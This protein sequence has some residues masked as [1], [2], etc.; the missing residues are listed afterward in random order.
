[1]DVESVPPYLLQLDS[2]NVHGFTANGN[3][4]VLLS[5]ASL[6]RD[7]WRGFRFDYV[8]TD[9]DLQSPEF[10]KV[11]AYMIMACL[12]YTSDAADE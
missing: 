4:V 8:Y 6:N 2:V 11:H 12:L 1:M 9:I 7:S 5:G 3:R 10:D